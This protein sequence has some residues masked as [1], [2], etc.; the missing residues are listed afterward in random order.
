MLLQTLGVL[1]QGA[2]IYILFLHWRA[3][4]RHGGGFLA[5]GWALI[6]LGAAPWFFGVS[7]ERAMALAAFAP[8]AFGLAFL[9]PDAL[10]RLGAG[11]TRKKLNPVSDAGDS[12]ALRP[13]STL[14]NAGRWFAALIAAPL[15]ALAGAAAFQALIPGSIA[16]RT[17]FSGFLAIAIWTAALLWLLADAKPWRAVGFACAGA[18]LLSALVFMAV[19]RGAA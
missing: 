3:R 13:G 15:L 7:L 6:L 5:A 17:V 19:S 12:E 10:P 8:M 1:I 2:G 14:R 4:R 18:L 16:D 11:A 9:A